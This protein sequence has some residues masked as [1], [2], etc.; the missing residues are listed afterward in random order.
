MVQTLKNSGKKWG[1]F[2]CSFS[3]RQNAIQARAGE[4]I[5]F[6]KRRRPNSFLVQ[7]LVFTQCTTQLSQKSTASNLKQSRWITDIFFLLVLESIFDDDLQVVNA[8]DLIDP[9]DE[10]GDFHVHPWDVLPAAAEAPGD[11]AGQLVVALVL[12]DKGTA[13]VALEIG[14]YC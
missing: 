8:D 14:V 4:I 10:G 5:N 13:A 11:E 3:W 7:G 2:C 1:P 9:P 12:A 6:W